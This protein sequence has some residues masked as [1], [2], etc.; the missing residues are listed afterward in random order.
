MKIFQKRPLA[1]LA[2][3]TCNLFKNTRRHVV[4]GHV[5]STGQLGYSIKGF[6]RSPLGNRLGN[7]RHL[8]LVFFL[9]PLQKH[10]TEDLC[11][12]RGQGS[13]TVERKFKHWQNTRV[14]EQKYCKKQE[15]K[16]QNKG[17][18]CNTA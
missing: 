8:L 14:Q 4:T 15:N 3:G 1:E 6:Q 5:G 12:N 9:L 16:K 17:E 7:S 2:F 13:S 11:H 10:I 18:I